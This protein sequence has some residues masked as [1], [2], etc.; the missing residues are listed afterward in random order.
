[1][2]L[3]VLTGLSALLGDQLSLGS[4][5]VCNSVAQNQLLV[6][7][8]TGR[9]LSQAAPWFLG[10]GRVHLSSSGGAHRLGCTP[11]WLALSWSDL[12]MEPCGRGSAPV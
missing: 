9:L 10:S 5:F 6:Q 7:T 8:E 3:P 1:M 11:G 4:I 2:V 12:G